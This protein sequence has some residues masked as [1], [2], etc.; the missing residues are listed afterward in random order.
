MLES[1][2]YFKRAGWLPNTSSKAFIK[3]LNKYGPL[4]IPCVVPLFSNLFPLTLKAIVNNALLTIIK[5]Y[6]AAVHCML[7]H[8]M[9]K[10]LDG[11]F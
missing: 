3:M 11:S 6:Q 7:C 9:G 10:H 1:S 5:N 2:A 8:V 4:T